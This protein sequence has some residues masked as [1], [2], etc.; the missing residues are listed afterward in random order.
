MLRCAG[1]SDR[2][3][4]NKKNMEAP[5]FMRTCLSL[6]YNI[7]VTRGFQLDLSREDDDCWGRSEGPSPPDTSISLFIF[8]T[9]NRLFSRNHGSIMNL[10]KTVDC[11]AKV[12]LPL[13][14]SK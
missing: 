6:G 10:V 7:T 9:P 1:R 4:E 12:N 2:R 3:V 11:K 14:F 13:Q 5:P 8:P